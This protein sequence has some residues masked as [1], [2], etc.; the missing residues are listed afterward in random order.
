[1]ASPIDLGSDVITAGTALAGLVLVFVGALSTSF[2]SYD[3]TEK[4]SVRL[5]YQTRLW[6]AFT[7]F[8]C[9]VG[10]ALLAILGK[11]IEN[12]C[13]AFGSLSLLLAAFAFVVVTALI[14]VR[15]VR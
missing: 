12:E 8:S 2:D 14:A 5:R 7:G 11:W 9:A 4:K 13:L 3:P 15:D 6:F 10:A 1:M